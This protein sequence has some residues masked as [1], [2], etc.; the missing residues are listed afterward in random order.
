MNCYQS[1]ADPSEE[2][3]A[4]SMYAVIANPAKYE[5]LGIRIT[6]YLRRVDSVLV[7]YPSRDA[8]VY[9]AGRD[10]IELLV[11]NPDVIEVMRGKQEMEG[12]ATVIGNFTA[13]VRG[14]VQGSVGVVSGEIVVFAEEEPGVP[15]RLPPAKAGSPG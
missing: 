14:R 7:L 10:G 11:E 13:K 8:Y 4:A 6:G 12:A 15:P 3:C 5:G 9:S 2:V 1:F